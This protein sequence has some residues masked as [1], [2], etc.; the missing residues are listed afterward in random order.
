[1]FFYIYIC[2]HSIKLYRMLI[3]CSMS[4]LTILKKMISRQ[5]LMMSIILLSVHLNLYEIYN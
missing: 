3:K 5:L 2:T 4:K 1:L